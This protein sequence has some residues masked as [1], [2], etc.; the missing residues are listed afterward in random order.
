MNSVPAES[1]G[2]ASGMRAT[3]Q[4]A[5]TVLSMGIFFTIVAIGLASSL[6]FALL[7]GLTHWGVPVQVASQVA[8]LPPTSALFAAFLGYNPMSVLLPASVLHTLP[9]ASQTTLLGK[10]FFPNTISAPFM[11][12]L[13]AVFYLSVVMCLISALA[14]LLRGQ[15]YIHGQTEEP[16]RQPDTMVPTGD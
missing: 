4:N 15:R 13:H 2:V 3:F 11:V 1:R 7:S 8:S 10:S 12:G 16:Q 6:P 5:A 14:S 9:A